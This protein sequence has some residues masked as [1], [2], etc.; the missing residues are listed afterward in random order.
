MQRARDRLAVS[1]L[2]RVALALELG[3]L[4]ERVVVDVEA[5]VDHV[6]AQVAGVADAL[7]R[8]ADI[9]V[10]VRVADLDRHERHVGRDTGHADAVLARADRARDVR[11]VELVVDAR[12][13]AADARTVRGEVRAVGAVDVRLAVQ[14]E[15]EVVAV[16]PGVDDSDFDARLAQ[17]A[18]VGLRR[19]DHVHVPLHR[20]ERIGRARG[21][22]LVDRVRG[23]DHELAAVERLLV[24]RELLPAKVLADLLDERVALE[25]PGECG[26]FR[27]DDEHAC[28]AGQVGR[29][30]GRRICLHDQ[31]QRVVTRQ[32]VVLVERICVEQ[33][34]VAAQRVRG[35]VVGQRVRAVEGV[36]ARLRG[37]R[38]AGSERVVG[39]QRVARGE[40]VL[41]EQRVRLVLR[42][43]RRQRVLVEQRVGLVERVEGVVVAQRVRAV[44]RLGLRLRDEGVARTECVAAVER[45]VTLEDDQVALA[46]RLATERGRRDQNSEQGDRRHGRLGDRKAGTRAGI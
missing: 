23:Q 28:L 41:T 45:V 9:A 32:G 12:E 2:R 35:G 43:L 11:A 25:R 7:D 1:A 18:Q 19:A 33:R 14:L 22:M 36:R 5:H 39:A 6:Q 40:R 26:V 42:V 37:K 31:P 10:A 15:V 24:A 8:V 4:V 3:R 13:R 27:V 20:G 46:R 38:V 16:D 44:H 17:L 29:D 30:E 21:R 34:V